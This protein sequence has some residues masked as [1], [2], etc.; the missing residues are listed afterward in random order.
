MCVETRTPTAAACRA[1]AQ[2][3]REAAAEE[4]R[5]EIRDQLLRIAS[6]FERLAASQE[7][8]DSKPQE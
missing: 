8:L 3:L 4:S 2:L 1:Q 5:I 6:D 7:W